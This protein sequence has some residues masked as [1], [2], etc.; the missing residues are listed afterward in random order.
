MAQLQDELSPRE[1]ARLT[2]QVFTGAST[3]ARLMRAQRTL[4]GSNAEGFAKAIN[5]TLDELF[6]VSCEDFERVVCYYND[7]GDLR[8]YIV[9]QIPLA[10][11]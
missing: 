4:K 2:D 11:A 6:A 1:L 5:G 10:N 7:C 3:I 9:V 8:F